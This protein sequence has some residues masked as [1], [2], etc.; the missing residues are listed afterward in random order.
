MT[1]TSGRDDS[2]STDSGIDPRRRRLLGMAAGASAAA[3][4]PTTG[5]VGAESAETVT[6]VHD[7]HFH[8][9]FEDAEAAALNLPRYYT[10]VRDALADADN[11]LFVGNGDDIAPS[12][13]G[14]EFEGEH[15]IEALNA[16]ELDVVGVGNHEY[17][18]GADVATERFE[19]SEFPWVVAN[20]LDD[21]GEP[22]PGTERWATFEEGDL[23]VGVF[24]LVSTNF[25]SLTDYPESWQVLGYVEGAQEAVD[26]LREEAGADVVVC[27]SHVSTG[28]HYTLAEEVDGLDAIVGS[29]SNVVFDEPERVD[30]TVISEF[31]DEFDHVGSL[32]LDA[33]GEL[34]DWQRTDLLPPEADPDPVVDEYEEIGVRYADE[35][36]E[37]DALA[38]VADDWSEKLEAELGAPVVE[39]EVELNATFDNYAI[40]T[41]WG[42][43]VTDAMR[44]V[45]EIGD[46]EVDIAAQNGGGIR[47]GSTYGPGEITGADVMNILPFPNEIEVV[48]L[49]GEDVVAYLEEAIRPHPSENYGTQPAIQVS[50]IS[51]E[52]WGHDGEARVENVFVGGE[53]IDPDET[54]S[55]AHNDYSIG[56]SDVLSE[57]EVVLASG[58]YQ[59][60]FVIDW[61]EER[62]T[63][64]PERE[65]RMLRVDET[66]GEASV[67]AG[68]G[69]AVLTVDVP[70]GAD[71]VLP[72]T[73]RAVIR[74]GADLEAKSATRNGDS[75]DVTFDTDDLLAL[76]ADVDEPALRLFGGYDPDQEYWDYDFEVPTSSGYDHFRLRAEVSAATLEGLGDDSNG[77]DGTDDDTDSN[78]TDEGDGSGDSGNG[79]T[80][81]GSGNGSTD[82]GSGN[83]STDDGSGDGSADDGSDDSGNGS[84]G[85]GSDDG[86]SGNGSDDGTPGFG[87]L[88]A[89]AGGSVGGYLYSRRRAAGDDEP[90]ETSTDGADD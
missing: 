81:D 74:T 3:V 66:V 79:S 2:D 7:T 51:Y 32:T 63:V 70:D 61:L 28:V 22:V 10:V 21:A 26:A 13:M 71:E 45:G 84:S 58:Q 50:G 90:T 62:D 20:L 31:G 39:S 37:D 27:A 68:D 4:L 86:S 65:N 52:W 82:D 89:I 14:L 6:I 12:V 78:E 64:A 57:A 38:A 41:N 33:D 40:E 8:G 23:T 49:T 44:T 24:G 85:N 69:E 55:L 53:P 34:V 19:E 76:V 59:G 73:F 56:N 43:L 18:F 29:H 36:E 16:T 5:S 67:A 11:A 87:P 9:R 77:N 80:D 47:S 1:G 17:D 48:E 42:N 25:H 35:I 46:I 60:P 54:Y 15:M 75:V 30:G 83:G 88:G 72:D